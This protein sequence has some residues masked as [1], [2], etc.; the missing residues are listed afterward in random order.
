MR[1]AGTTVEETDATYLGSE[2]L[3]PPHEIQRGDRNLWC[4]IKMVLYALSVLFGKK[5]SELEEG[6]KDALQ[7]HEELP[8]FATASEDELLNVFLD[9]VP[10]QIRLFRDHLLITGGAG[11]GL[12]LLKTLSKNKLGDESL[13]LPDAGRN[14]GLV[15]RP[16]FALWELNRLI[17]LFF[18]LCLLRCRIEWFRRPVK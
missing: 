2:N 12:G 18:S 16:S 3:A 7:W 5:L 6:Q 14:R 13:A 4:S 17:Q 8:D 15:R 10:L 1:T 9:S 11:I